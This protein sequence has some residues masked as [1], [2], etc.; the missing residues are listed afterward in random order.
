M[1]TS[2]TTCLCNHGTSDG[3]N[4]GAAEASKNRL[5]AGLQHKNDQRWHVVLAILYISRLK[6]R[7]AMGASLI[8]CL[9]NH[10]N[11]CVVNEG[12]AEFSIKL[13]N[14]GTSS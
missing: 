14:V 4:E 1:G 7:G 12:A 5:L 8:M 6:R 10:G 13:L 2:L 11:Y 3:V 9:C